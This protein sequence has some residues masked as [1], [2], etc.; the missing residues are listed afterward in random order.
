MSN[1][2]IVLGKASC[3]LPS[4]R[5]RFPWLGG[6]LQTLKNTIHFSAPD[7]NPYPSRRLRLPL[8]DGSGDELWALLNVP[9]ETRPK[10]A[11]VLIHGLT[12]SETSRNIQTSTA[13]Y[14]S[15]G[16][17]VLRLNLR[18]AGPS[19]GE[20]R[21]FYHAGRS[22]D[23]RDAIASLPP[24][25]CA[26]GLFLVG[27][28]LGGN[29]LLKCLAERAGLESVIGAASVCAPIDLKAA[30]VRIME[31]RNHLYQAHLLKCLIRDAQYVAHGLSLADRLPVI[32]TIFD[33]DDLIVAPMGGFSGAEDY[34]R[35]SS[36][37]SLLHMIEKPT[38]LITAANDPWIPVKSYL[39][40][41]WPTGG[42]LT[43]AITAG[44]GHVGFHAEGNPVPWHNRA[45]GAFIDSLL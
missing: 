1:S 13:Y 4:F 44:G 39:D 11:V 28:S 2:P 8:R 7:L 6:D 38:L 45:I 5:A 22:A 10:P 15:R 3:P 19:L 20:C 43:A 33:F 29:L 30:Q 24:D 25:L 18:N 41:A 32:R 36:A 9:T 21:H 31:P 12:G 17:P 16:F 26:R 14:L 23:L 27:V 42:S 37:G 35:R 34:Y 40:R